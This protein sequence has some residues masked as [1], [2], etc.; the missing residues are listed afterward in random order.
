MIDVKAKIYK[1]SF[2]VTEAQSAKT[3]GCGTLDVLSTPIM[4]AFMEN[5]AMESLV[6]PNKKTS[7]GIFLKVNHIRPTAIGNEVEVWSKVINIDGSQ[8][9]FEINA[10]CDSKEIGNCIHKRVVVEAQ[11]FMERLHSL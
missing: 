2:F 10:F 5:A 4:I 6:L 8:V 1:K 11:S 9:T 7:V 3:I